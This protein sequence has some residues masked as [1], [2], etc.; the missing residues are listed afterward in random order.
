[1]D[2]VSWRTAAELPSW[3]LSLLAPPVR[4]LV[5][6][7][8]HFALD[9]RYEYLSLNKDSFNPLGGNSYYYPFYAGHM[10]YPGDIIMWLSLS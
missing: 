1:M 7:H 9:L 4:W 5:G 3:P 2:V 8:L 10:D 6:L